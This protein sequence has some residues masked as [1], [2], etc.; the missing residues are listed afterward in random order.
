M[1]NYGIPQA[2]G[3]LTALQPGDK[4]TLFNAE[5][6]APPQASVAF[7]RGMGMMSADGGS[8][9]HASFATPPTAAVVNIQA[10]N[11]DIDADYTNVGTLTF[12]GP[13]TDQAYTDV[14]RSAFYRA[15]LASQSGGGA[16]TV[17]VQR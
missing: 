10:A 13:Q 4:L 17:T 12:T 7:A 1:P 11:Q 5:S 9:F 16:I 8:T 6:P 3:T 2:G 14:G 15:Q